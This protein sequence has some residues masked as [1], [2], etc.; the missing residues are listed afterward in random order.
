MDGRDV[1]KLPGRF[2]NH[3][4]EMETGRSRP[5]LEMKTT[6]DVNKSPCWLSQLQEDESV[7]TFEQEAVGIGK[8]YSCLQQP[9]PNCP[10]GRLSSEK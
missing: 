2:L 5:S 1:L 6:P 9:I 3:R 7:M 4:P 8:E 10:I